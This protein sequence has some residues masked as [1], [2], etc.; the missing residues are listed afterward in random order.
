MIKGEKKISLTVE[1]ILQR[2]SEY[3]IYRHF[4]G[5]FKVNEVMCNKMRNDEM[6]S[7][8][9]GNRNGSLSH[10]DFGNDYWRG[11]CFKFVEQLYNCS[12]DEALKIIDKELGLGIL[13]DDSSHQTYKRLTT[14]YKQPEEE[15]GRRYSF[16]QAITRKFTDEELEYWKNYYQT[17]SDLRENNVH[18]ISSLFL[19]RKRMILQPLRFGYLY[20]KQW[21]KLYQPFAPKKQ[22]WISNVPLKTMYGL[23][24][25]DKEHNTLVTKS[26]KDYLVCRRVYP[27]VCHVQNESLA[28]FSEENVRFINENS[29]EVFYGGDNDASGKQASYTITQT[30]GWRHIN[31]P[32]KFLSEKVTDFADMAK[33]N[34]L[35]AV[36]EHF[37]KKQLIQ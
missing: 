29:R 23:N 4:Y 21:W 26:M 24:N 36:R 32:D 3:D 1:N 14:G 28:A 34:S 12:F 35:E 17:L 16:I 15:I 2:V 31:V 8:V 27:H 7:F 25:L 22:K 20:E 6:P 33:H 37:I 5:E 13:S 11:N 9:I 18:S 19:N 30:F 10:Y